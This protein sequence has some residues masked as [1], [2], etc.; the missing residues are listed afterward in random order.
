MSQDQNSFYLEDENRAVEELEH[1]RSVVTGHFYQ[2]RD[3][4]LSSQQLWKMRVDLQ[5]ACD[6]IMLATRHIERMQRYIAETEKAE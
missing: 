5:D 6:T 3:E 1:A 2:L 4:A